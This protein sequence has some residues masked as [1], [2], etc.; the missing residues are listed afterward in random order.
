MWHNCEVTRVK[1]KKNS[2][3]LEID[4]WCW[5]WHCLVKIN[6]NDQIES[7][8]RK[9]GSNWDNKKFEDQIEIS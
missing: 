6:S 4:T 9:W 7:L 3:K 2:K 1:D 5:L 8:L